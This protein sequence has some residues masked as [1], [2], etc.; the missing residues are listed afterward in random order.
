MGFGGVPVIS[1]SFGEEAGKDIETYATTDSFDSLGH[2][3]L[4]AV[5]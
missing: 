3:E 4:P 5:Q 1:A 2:I